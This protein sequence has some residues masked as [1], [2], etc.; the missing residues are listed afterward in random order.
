MG[1]RKAL[2]ESKMGLT[3]VKKKGTKASTVEKNEKEK[4][5]QWGEFSRGRNGATYPEEK[6]PDDIQKAPEVVQKGML[7]MVEKAPEVVEKEMTKVVL[8][9]PEVVQKETSNETQTAS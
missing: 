8:Q 1:K 9:A 7:A 3:I 5:I 4:G 2:K 6:V